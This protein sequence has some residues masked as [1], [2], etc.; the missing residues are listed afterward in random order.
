MESLRRVLSLDAW[1]GRRMQ[2]GG[3]EERAGGEGHP[4]ARH[5]A[6]HDQRLV[7]HTYSLH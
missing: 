2:T 3:R 7:E 6:E 1:Q 5:N 4:L